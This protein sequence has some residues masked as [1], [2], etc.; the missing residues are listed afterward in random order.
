[1]SQSLLP[2]YLESVP[3]TVIADS[4]PSVESGTISLIMKLLP[5]KFVLDKCAK[6]INDLKLQRT[7][8]THFPLH[9][10]QQTLLWISMSLLLSRQQSFTLTSL[11][12]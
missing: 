2:E 3:F 12:H 8:L 9:Q 10:A 4:E 11:F 5:V 1:M 7:A 6:I